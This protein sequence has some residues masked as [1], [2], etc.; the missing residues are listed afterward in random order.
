MDTKEALKLAAEDKEGFVVIPHLPPESEIAMSWLAARLPKMVAEGRV[1]Q[2]FD[3]A[4]LQRGTT[5]YFCFR[6]PTR[7]VEVAAK[8]D[9][10]KVLVRRDDEALAAEVRLTEPIKV[11]AY[12]RQ[13]PMRPG[14]VDMGAM[15][16]Q[17]G[18]LLTPYRL[19][20]SDGASPNPSN[21]RM[22]KL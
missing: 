7:P 1:Y 13:E 20:Y 18:V 12:W 21:L 22:T 15:M 19:A 3:S 8:V 10:E 9:G 6:D 5:V 14:R 11:A 17:A 2:E 16:Q 4:S